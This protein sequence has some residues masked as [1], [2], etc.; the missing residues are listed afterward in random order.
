MGQTIALAGTGPNDNATG[1][2][3]SAAQPC[4]PYVIT[5]VTASTITVSSVLA[6]GTFGTAT[7]SGVLPSPSLV[8]GFSTA[9]Q[10]DVKTGNGDN[11][12]QYNVNAPVSVDG[13][14]GFD[15]MSC[16][17]PSSPTTSWSPPQAIYGAGLQSATATCDSSRST[18]SRA[19]TPSTCCRTALGVATRILGG[20]GSDAINVAG[21]VVG[22]VVSRDPNGSHATINQLITSNDPNYNNIV[23]AGID[24]SVARPTQ[25]AVIITETGGFTDVRR[26]T[27]DSSIGSADSYTVALA[28]APTSDVW[29]TVSAALSPAESRPGADTVYLCT[30]SASHCA[31]ADNYFRTVYVDGVAQ[32]EGLGGSGIANR[33]LVLHFTTTDWNTPQT[34][35][36]AAANDTTPQGD[37]VVTVSHSVVSADSTYATAVVRNVEATVHDNLTPGVVLVQRDASGNPDTTTTVIKGTTVTQLTDTFTV[38]LP[39]IPTGSVTYLITPTDARLILSSMDGRFTLGAVI[40]GIQTYEIAFTAADWDLPVTITT[41]AV[42]NFQR[43][44]PSYTTL[45]VTVAAIGAG[46]DAAYDTVSSM[47]EVMVLDDNTPGVYSSPSGGSTVVSA[48]SGTD[49]GITDSYTVRLLSAPTATVTI[50]LITDGQTVIATDAAC[51]ATLLG[52]VCLVSVGGAAAQPVITFDQTNWWIP[53]TVTVSAN[54]AYVLPAGRGDL[55]TFPKQPHLLSALRGPLQVDGGTAG[56]HHTLGNAVI[57]PHEVNTPPF[58]IG[59]QPSEARQVDVLNVFDD[60]SRADQTGDLTS[61]ALTGFGMGPSDHL[62]RHH[63][64]G[65][66]ERVPRRHQLRHHLG[67]R[68]RHLRHGCLEDHHRSAQRD[69]RPGQRPADHAQHHDPGTGPGHRRQAAHRHPGA[70]RRAHRAAG[71]RQRAACRSPDPSATPPTR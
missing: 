69:A 71:R 36:V 28:A 51:G 26:L 16:S 9:A 61:T 19:T 52:H 12:V 62:R 27:N 22:D 68:E 40:D 55:F 31:S 63:L 8:S 33:A 67:G 24:V 25:G 5:A 30:G 17:A 58:G 70:A 39:S 38:A 43:E 10:T 4:L 11:Q 50:A 57:L 32:Y 7:V 37:I 60:G 53:V 1:C 15:K 13:G 2:A 29:I 56:Q 42:D 46:R 66:A 64:L 47:L 41:G 65:R 21:D 18:G 48:P 59:Q 34:V 35:W 3:A 49:A 45:R 44:D 54:R 23:A 6:A 20:L 14:S